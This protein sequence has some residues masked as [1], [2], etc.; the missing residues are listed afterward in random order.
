MLNEVKKKSRS[1]T[2]IELIV[3]IFIIALL[4]SIISINLMSARKRSRDNKRRA[5]VNS[6]LMA[7]EM[8]Y[9]KTATYRLGTV[10]YGVVDGIGGCT[11]TTSIANC[12]IATGYMSTVPQ[13]PT[14]GQHYCVDAPGASVANFNR[15]VCIYAKLELGRTTEENSNYTQLTTGTNNCPVLAGSTCSVSVYN[16][17]VGHK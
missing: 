12:L 2:L 6:V 15:G 9:E 13:D 5:D 17:V 1:F 7:Y 11:A 10:G 8:N 16:F 4:A 14:S 3:V